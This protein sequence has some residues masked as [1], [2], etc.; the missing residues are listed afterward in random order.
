MINA[1][2]EIDQLVVASTGISSRLGSM[3]VKIGCIREP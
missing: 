3:R 1:V 2:K